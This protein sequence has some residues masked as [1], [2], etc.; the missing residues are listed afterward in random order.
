M[1]ALLL[2]GPS[3]CALLYGRKDSEKNKHCIYIVLQQRDIANVAGNFVH[4]QLATVLIALAYY[5][6][7]CTAIESL[8]ASQMH[9]I[10]Q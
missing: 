8:V 2:L 6:Y 5:N 7:I 3:S 4:S 9:K 10:V 1:V